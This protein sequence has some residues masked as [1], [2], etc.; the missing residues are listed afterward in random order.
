VKLHVVLLNY[1]TPDM[2]AKALDHLLVAL[3]PV[4]DTMVWVVDNDS[5]D[6]SEAKL[7]EKVTSLDDERVVFIQSGHNGGFGYGNNVGIRRAMNADDKPDYV[8]L[9]N[10]D[11]FVEPDA[12]KILVDFL[13]GRPDVGIAGSYIFGV[14]GV[15]HETAFRFPTVASELETT[16]RLGV[17]SRLLSEYIVALPMPT[18][19]TQVDWLAGCSMMIRRD[20]IEQV[21]MFDETFFLYYEETDLC[22]RA[23]EAGWSTWYVP[24]SRVAHIGSASTGMKETEKRTPHFW[25]DSRRHYFRKN[26]GQAYLVAADAAHVLGSLAWRA[27]RVVERKE[28]QDRPK[29]LRDFVRHAMKNF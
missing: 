27:R 12:V 29:A 11:A 4:P 20:V 5:Q 21:G 15:P 23:A 24:E 19:A 13:D 2:T 25:F 1:K 3:E 22:G 14:D 17:V 6:D 8:Y 7:K 16:L 26:Y 18:V 10:S 28:K 9:L